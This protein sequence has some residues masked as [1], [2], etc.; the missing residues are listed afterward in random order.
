MNIFQ[1]NTAVYVNIGGGLN[2][3]DS[4]S[5]QSLADLQSASLSNPPGAPPIHRGPRPPA[6]R[7]RRSLRRCFARAEAAG[8]RVA[9]A[10]RSGLTT[11]R[12]TR[13]SGQRDS[14][15]THRERF[16]PLG[17]EASG[18]VSRRTSVET[19]GVDSRVGAAARAEIQWIGGRLMDGR[20]AF[21]GS[22]S[23]GMAG[24][25]DFAPALLRASPES[26]TAAEPEM[27]YEGL[28]HGS[29]TSTHMLAGSVAGIMEHC[30]M[31][32]VDCVKVSDQR[33]TQTRRL[34]T[35]HVSPVYVTPNSPSPGCVNRELTQARHKARAQA[36]LA[37]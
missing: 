9:A 11:D 28:P 30:V 33:H 29:A 8:S 12:N 13:T 6:A 7:T 26:S 25:Q 35:E 32:P 4:R 21:V 31:Y 16:L 1:K 20:G 18:F 10:A 36:S 15:G 2:V 3:T 19:P 24:E 14:W 22:V 34:G 37:R 17:M 5:I 27:D 23:P